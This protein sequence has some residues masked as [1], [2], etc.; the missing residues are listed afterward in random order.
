MIY[1]IL[2]LP[3]LDEERHLITVDY[4]RSVAEVYLD[5]AIVVLKRT[6]DLSI[7]SRVFHDPE[8]DGDVDYKS[9][10]PQWDQWN[11]WSPFRIEGDAAYQQS[12]YSWSSDQLTV[13][14]QL[15][16][17]VEYVDI[18]MGKFRKVRSYKS[19]KAQSYPILRY[20]R[21]K[22]SSHPPPRDHVGSEMASLARTITAG[23][24][25]QEINTYEAA[26]PDDIKAYLES[27][28]AYINLLFPVS[29][30]KDENGNNSEQTG[31][32]QERVD[33]AGDSWKQFAFLADVMCVGRRIFQTQ[34]GVFDI[35]P[36][37]L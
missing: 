6:G 9:W 11:Q 32:T 4:N 2:G 30:D 12:N 36:G 31:S 8:H 7:F 13:Y 1:G 18:F 17:S 3:E 15:F 20:W 35:G 22:V 14:G 10:A 16:D 23:I 26:E 19:V 5:V 21:Q 34:N 33:Q 27:C 25:D 37:C 28:S 24:V 29:D